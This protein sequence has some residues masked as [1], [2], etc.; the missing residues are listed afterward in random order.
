MSQ[1]V[2]EKQDTSRVPEVPA[3]EAGPLARLTYLYSR[4]RYGRVPAPAR[5]YAHHPRL[6]AGYGVLELAFERS[7]RLEDRLKMLAEIRVAMVV[8]C[9]WCLDFGSWL[10]RGGVTEEQLR[11]LHRHGESEA[12]TPLEHLVLEY[13]DAASATPSAVDD[14]LVAQLRTHLDD[15]QMIELTTAIALENYRAR[16][17]HALG[18]APE[19]FSTGGFCPRPEAAA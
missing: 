17:N 18:L 8:G 11:E 15:P 7:K 10:A 2:A 19:G 9:E 14:E 12:F 4:R 5:V 3:S 6:M 1:I 16:F 13:A